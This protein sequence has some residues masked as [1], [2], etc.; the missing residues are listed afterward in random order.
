LQKTK[1]LVKC[2][3]CDQGI[4]ALSPGDPT[5]NMRET[6][7]IQSKKKFFRKMKSG[8][9]ELIFPPGPIKSGV[10]EGYHIVLQKKAQFTLNP[11]ETFL[12]PSH[13]DNDK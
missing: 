5:G 1:S 4:A 3:P 13:I 8:R 6:S 12:K 2:D 10:I 7:R 9:R 11:A